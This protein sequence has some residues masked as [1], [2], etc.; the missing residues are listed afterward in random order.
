MNT[1]IFLIL[2]GDQLQIKCNSVAFV[3]IEGEVSSLKMLLVKHCTRSV[4]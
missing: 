2:N 3:R 1:E 4:R